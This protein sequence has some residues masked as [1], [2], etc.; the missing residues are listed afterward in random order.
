MPPERSLHI[1]Q[2]QILERWIQ[3]GAIWP[4]GIDTVSEEDRKDHWSFKPLM[5]SLNGSIDDWIDLR[6]SQSE[7]SRSPTATSDQWLRRVTHDLT[8]LPPIRDDVA[9]LLQKL[10]S[11]ETSEIAY[12][13]VVDRLLASPRYGERWAQH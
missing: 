1:D 10:Q 9:S 4:D 13:A 5:R 11:G 2:I 3:Q 8:G 6:P 7:L 12:A